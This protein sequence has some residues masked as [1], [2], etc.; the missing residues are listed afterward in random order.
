VTIEFFATGD[1]RLDEAIRLRIAV[2]V[3]EQGVPL[4]E[5]ID[6]HDRSDPLALHALA[7]DDAGQPLGTGRFYA[8]DPGTAQIGRM[9]V[10]A[11]AR[12]TGVGMALLRALMQAARERGFTHAVLDAQVHAQPFY[13]KA[14]FE[15]FGATLMDAGIVHQ[16][17][18][19]ILG[20]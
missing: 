3:D 7:R 12:G 2:F 14:G 17:M 1:A 15:P 8:R 11:R 6:V 18:R 4:D 10:A 20:D 13:A 16:P 9:A 5:E 19:R